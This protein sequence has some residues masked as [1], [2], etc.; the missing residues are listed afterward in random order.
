MTVQMET[1]KHKS[2]GTLWKEEA[3]GRMS[4]NSQLAAV[5]KLR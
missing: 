2:N 5:A 3:L 4:R 1:I